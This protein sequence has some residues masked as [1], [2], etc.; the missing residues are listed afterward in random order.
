[1]PLRITKPTKVI[2]R[3]DNQTFGQISLRL[4]PPGSTETSPKLLLASQTSVVQAGAGWLPGM[5]PPPQTP[6]ETAESVTPTLSNQDL[7]GIGPV[8]SA[9]GSQPITPGQSS[10]EIDSNGDTVNGVTGF[11]LEI[12]GRQIVLK[13]N[14]ILTLKQGT[15]VTLVDLRTVSP[16]LADTVMNLRGFIGHPGDT[17][18]NDK[19]T[20]ADTS[21]DMIPRFS[22]ELNGRRVYQLGAE[23]GPELLAAAYL[24]IS[25]PHLRSVTLEAN[26]QE[27]TLALGQRW[28]L[29]PGTRVTVKEVLLDNQMELSNPKFTLGGRSFPPNLPQTLTMPTIAVSLAVF[30]D[31]E[32]AG[33]VVLFPKL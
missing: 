26:G 10:S 27:K 16:P 8:I 23:H 3:K 21:K 11:I 24:E 5:T 12:G 14:E 19:G 33:K 25:Q 31:N 17:T 32:L 28:G 20:T 7:E 29:A 1:M 2:A 4:L 18:G 30:T 15:K 6:P 22:M 13:P 9:A